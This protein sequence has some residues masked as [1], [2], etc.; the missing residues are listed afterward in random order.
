LKM[1]EKNSI[2]DMTFNRNLDMQQKFL[3]L[4]S[5]I[6]LITLAGC[7]TDRYI[8]YQT[9][10]QALID[11]A[12]INGKLV[13]KFTDEPVY[14]AHVIIEGL[15]TYSGSNGDFKF[16]YPLSEDVNR[17]KPVDINIMVENFFPFHVQRQIYPDLNEFNFSLTYAAPIIFDAAKVQDNKQFPFYY[18]QAVIRDYQGLGNI[19]KVTGIFPYAGKHNGQKELRQDLTLLE[20]DPLN[21]NTGHYQCQ[22]PFEA[23][24]ETYFYIEAVDRDGY[25]DR[26]QHAVDEINSPDKFLFSPF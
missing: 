18:I 12:T 1:K 25:S 16:I 10:G 7:D 14:G 13:N 15:E 19:K 23:P 21:A 17:T 6:L 9:K 22:I 11:Y 26:I 5:L 24:Y 2:L 3:I 20:S 8:G 4:F